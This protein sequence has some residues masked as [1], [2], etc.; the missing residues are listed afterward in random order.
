MDE[1]GIV[2]YDLGLINV[3]KTNA[4]DKIPIHKLVRYDLELMGGKTNEKNSGAMVL[5]SG[6]SR[7]TI[8]ITSPTR[9][10]RL[11]PLVS[12]KKAMDAPM[13]MPVKIEHTSN[14]LVEIDAKNNECQI[15]LKP[16]IEE[17]VTP[18]DSQEEI[19]YI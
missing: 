13:S 19:K 4:E 5:I 3:N 14:S 12:P 11:Q 15:Q 17:Q 6:R 10:T 9:S 1:L 8:G 16:V 7:S 18:A 2:E